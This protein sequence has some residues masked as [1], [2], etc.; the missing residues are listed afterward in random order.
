MDFVKDGY[1][2]GM[3]FEI[4]MY[5]MIECLEFASKEPTPN[6]YLQGRDGVRLVVANW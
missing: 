3:Y 1:L 5:E 6:V 4:F 2:L